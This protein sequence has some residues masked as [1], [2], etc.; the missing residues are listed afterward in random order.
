MPAEY[1]NKVLEV[2]SKCGQLIEDYEYMRSHKMKYETFYELYAYKQFTPKKG[3]KVESTP[4]QNPTHLVTP[5]V[6]MKKD[7]DKKVVS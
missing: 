4:S 5:E 3:A 2:Q 7:K 1:T 6:N